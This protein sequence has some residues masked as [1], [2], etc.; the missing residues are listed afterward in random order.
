MLE[1]SLCTSAL[2]LGNPGDGET[3]RNGRGERGRE[4]GREGGG[5]TGVKLV[6]LLGQAGPS[7]VAVCACHLGHSMGLSMSPLH[8][9]GLSMSSLLPDLLHVSLPCGLE[10]GAS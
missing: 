10:V 2:G 6:M 3:Q 4:G 8:S 1:E 9:M 7:A 5:V